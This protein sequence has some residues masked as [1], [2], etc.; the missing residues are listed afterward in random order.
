MTNEKARE[1]ALETLKSAI[2]NIDNRLNKNDIHGIQIE[3]PIRLIQ[4][5]IDAAIAMGH[6]ANTNGDANPTVTSHY[7]PQVINIDLDRLRARTTAA[8]AIG[9]SAYYTSVGHADPAETTGTTP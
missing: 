4:I 7:T 2:E 3:D 6:I 9:N 1:H 5:K 8:P